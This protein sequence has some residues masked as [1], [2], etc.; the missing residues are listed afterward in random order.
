MDIYAM[1]YVKLEAVWIISL[2]ND[3]DFFLQSKKNLTFCWIDIAHTYLEQKL[4]WPYVFMLFTVFS[5]Q[6]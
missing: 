2:I 3:S 6:I 1:F 5:S 4:D